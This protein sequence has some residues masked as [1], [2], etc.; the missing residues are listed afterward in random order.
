M[1]R[2]GQAWIRRA[3]EVRKA[4]VPGHRFQTGFLMAHTPSVLPVTPAVSQADSGCMQGVRGSG[5][6]ALLPSPS[7]NASMLPACGRSRR[8]QEPAGR[9]RRK[10]PD[11]APRGRRL[12]RARAATRPRGASFGQGR[13]AQEAWLWAEAGARRSSYTAVPQEWAPRML[14]WRGGSLDGHPHPIATPGVCAWRVGITPAAN[15]SMLRIA[16]SIGMPP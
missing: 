16:S 10:R 9:R 1:G 7:S 3:G 13:R 4:T 8:V 6:S 5:A 15:V 12:L 14:R 2:G 11:C